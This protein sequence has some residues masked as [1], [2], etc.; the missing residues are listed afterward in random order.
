MADEP[1]S[2]ADWAFGEY[3]AGRDRAGEDDALFDGVLTDRERAGDVRRG[4]SRVSDDARDTWPVSQLSR[5]R[6][7][8]AVRSAWR[9]PGLRELSDPAPRR[10]YTRRRFPRTDPNTQT[11]S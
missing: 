2:S 3:F 6:D 9:I 7:E 5:V 4:M 8:T 1:P 10:A 11:Q